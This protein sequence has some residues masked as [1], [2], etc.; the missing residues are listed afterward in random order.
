[1]AEAAGWNFTVWY[2]GTLHCKSVLQEEGNPYL[3]IFEDSEGGKPTGYV[4]IKLL[5]EE[6]DPVKLKQT[7]LRI[8]RQDEVQSHYSSHYVVLERIPPR[9][10]GDKLSISDRVTDAGTIAA[11]VNYW[12]GAIA[13]A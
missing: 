9:E 6:K 5:N 8:G 11:K 2:W 1:M 12:I 4:F 10:D 7:L 3:D 13:H